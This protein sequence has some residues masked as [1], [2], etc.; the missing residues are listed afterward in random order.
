[1]SSGGKLSDG[2]PRRTTAD[3]G[4]EFDF[5]SYMGETDL[6]FISTNEPYKWEDDDLALQDAALNSRLPYDKMT[7]Q[8]LQCFSEDAKDKRFRN[9]YLFVRN[10]ILSLWLLNPLLE[11]TLKNIIKEMPKPYNSDRRLLEAVHWFLQRYGFINYGVF[12]DIEIKQLVPPKVVFV[13]GSGISGLIA[14]RQLQ[15]FGFEVVVLEGKD[16]IGGRILSVK[17]E[18]TK[19]DGDKSPNKISDLG[20]D[21]VHGIV[22]N[23][24]LTLVKQL[25]VNITQFKS[26][27]PLFTE[28]GSSITDERAKGICNTFETLVETSNVIASTIKK[29]ET[30]TLGKTLTHLVNQHELR[31]RNR[32]L[33][34]WEKRVELEKK[35]LLAIKKVKIC[36]NGIKECMARMEKHWPG[37]S[38]ITKFDKNN[39]PPPLTE[40]MDPGEFNRLVEIRSLRAILARILEMYDTA[41]EDRNELQNMMKDFRLEESS[42]NFMNT[43]DRQTFNWH[44]ATLEHHLGASI[45]KCSLKKR[46]YGEEFG[47]AGSRFTI[48]EGMH[49]LIIELAKGLNV[50]TNHIVREIQYT[51]KR[52]VIHCTIRGCNSNAQ[53]MHEIE[54][55]A[56]AVLC[57]ASLGVLKKA[58]NNGTGNHRDRGISFKPELPKWK[59]EAIKNVGFGTVNKVILHFEKRFWDDKEVNA[60]FGFVNKSPK[61]RGENYLFVVNQ[62]HPS[63]SAYFV[64]E[65]AC[66]GEAVRQK[67]KEDMHVNRIQAILKIVLK[68]WSECKIRNYSTMWELDRFHYGSHSFFYP[69]TKSS[70]FEDLARPLCSPD[71]NIPYVFFAG[72]HTSAE[73]VGTAHGAFISGLRAAA[74]I[75]DSF[76][77]PPGMDC[78]QHH[79]YESG[80]TSSAE[81][82]PT[83]SSGET[84]ATSV[85][86]S[87]QPTAGETETQEAQPD[88][89]TE[90]TPNDPNFDPKTQCRV[91]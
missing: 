9:S 7:S 73:W 81:V 71:D 40:D 41:T 8:E 22:G 83:T 90:K 3:Y 78:K 33:K 85:V 37:F 58:D 50:K 39:I 16:K 24:L 76:F 32:A 2:R 61:C 87:S 56:D 20:A 60:T 14:A 19:S 25:P 15:F 88:P 91:T 1:M 27:C 30:L 51:D 66:I 23:P 75:A 63:I 28:S 54:Y 38:A 11:L 65:S 55:S 43:L 70:D 6:H 84:P 47:F 79:F 36:E 4:D 26:G 77:G 53:A 68:K 67:E 59:R 82:P 44:I 29:P 12:K 31:V 57:T 34:Y 72:E 42:H 74:E 86:C 18:F 17:N 5:L 21:I 48:D 35:M 13:I 45:D 69:K 10:K 49:S 52:V 46:N 64:G 62:N 80:S 89:E